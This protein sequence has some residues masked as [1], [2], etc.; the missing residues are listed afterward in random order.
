MRRFEI[1]LENNYFYYGSIGFAIMVVIVIGFLASRGQQTYTDKR[2][3]LCLDADFT[4]KQCAYF[5]SRR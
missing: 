2:M 4:P 1:L 5:E 3:H